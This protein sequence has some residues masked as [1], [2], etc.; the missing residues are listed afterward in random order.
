MNLVWGVLLVWLVFK[1]SQ[2]TFC[3]HLQHFQGILFLPCVTKLF[4]TYTFLTQQN[5][6]D[7]VH[8][9]SILLS[10]WFNINR[11]NK[12][13]LNLSKCNLLKYANNKNKNK[14]SQT[15]YVNQSVH[16]KS[17]VFRSTKFKVINENR[18]LL[19]NK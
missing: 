15:N 13:R 14:A 2:L 19:F 3:K 6:Q 4:K 17:R 12:G 8:Y 7:N 1:L 10:Y 9:L 5:V 18:N 11:I 16:N